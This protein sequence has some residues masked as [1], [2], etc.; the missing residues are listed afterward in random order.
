MLTIMNQCSIQNKCRRSCG[1]IN[2]PYAKICIPDVTKSLD[3]KVFNLMQRLN[4]TR[5][6]IWHKT[7][8]C[9]YRLASAVCNNKQIWD[10]VKCRCECKEELIDKGICDNGFVW[11]PSN[12]QCECV[13]SCGIS[14]YLDY[15]S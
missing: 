2:N 14:Q 15:K 4:E 8:K 6:I 12:C 13:K 10:E 5:R 7:C 9:V 3:V 11:N 1:S